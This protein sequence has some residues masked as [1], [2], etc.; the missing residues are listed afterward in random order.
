MILQTGG[1]NGK[2]AVADIRS[3]ISPSVAKKQADQAVKEVGAFGT[4]FQT[5][6]TDDGSISF[7]SHAKDRLGLR[8]INLTPEEIQRLSEGISKASSKGAKQSLLVMENK[9]F[10][11]GVPSRTVITA[12][13]ADSMRAKVFINIDSAVFV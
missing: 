10:I 8:G 9:A 1:R 4:L 3:G 6:V 2:D 13:D 11:V 5:A 12:L 7:S